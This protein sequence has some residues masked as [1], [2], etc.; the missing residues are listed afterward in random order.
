MGLA[1]CGRTLLARGAADVCLR[2][3][4]GGRR[5]DPRNAHQTPCVVLLC[6][7]DRISCAAARCLRLLASHGARVALHQAGECTEELFSPRMQAILQLC[8]D[9]RCHSV[10]RF[11][12]NR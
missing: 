3:V 5:L 10:D 11:T 4:G 9:R 6:G 8:S 7:A 1:E 12:S 2:L